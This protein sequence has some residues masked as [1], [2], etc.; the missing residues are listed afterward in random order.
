MNLKTGW[1]IV[2]T[3]GN[4]TDGREIKK[5]WLTE[6]AETYNPAFYS[7]KVWPNHLREWG[8][9][10]KVLALKTQPATD[11]QLKGEI[12]LMA[13]MSPSEDLVYM[14]KRGR[15]VHTSIE[16]LK[17]FAGKG[18]AYLGG[19]AVTDNPASLGTTELQF[20]E[21][22]DTFHFSGEHLD[23]S[24]TTEEKQSFVEKLFNPK[25]EQETDM[26]DEQ[27][28]QL[29]DAQTETN[30]ALNA[31][32]EKFTSQPAPKTE[33]APKA[34]PAPKETEKFVSET[35]FNELSKKLDTLTTTFE[36]IRKK[37]AG[38][39]QPGKPEGEATPELL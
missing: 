22:S 1:V 11:E 26:K 34:D 30:K 20:S 6:M 21:Q 10:G 32:V 25:P 33:P 3:S 24:S 29:L 28:K 9:Q 12:H 14:N 18:K 23:L 5:E 38:A 13:I 7:A 15:W 17:N 4:T 16:V 19:L 35:Q 36:E 8:S 27:F 37:P 39:T 31:L 2:A